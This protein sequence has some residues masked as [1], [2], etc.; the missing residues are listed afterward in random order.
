MRQIKLQKVMVLMILSLI[1]SVASAFAA[2]PI[3][4]AQIVGV[5]GPYEAYTKQST[6]GFKMGLE[7]ATKVPSSNPTGESNF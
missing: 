2:E 1:F 7:Y 6:D 3:K 5:T 4:I